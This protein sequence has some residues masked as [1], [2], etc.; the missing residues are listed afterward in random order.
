MSQKRAPPSFIDDTVNSLRENDTEAP[1]KCFDDDDVGLQ[2]KRSNSSLSPCVETKEQ[3][4]QN[5]SN[6]QVLRNN[7]IIRE[8]SVEESSDTLQKNEP[9]ISVPSAN[10]VGVNSNNLHLPLASLI[11]NTQSLDD[12]SRASIMKDLKECNRKDTSRQIIGEY[13][14]AN[15]LRSPVG[16]IPKSTHKQSSLPYYR[17]RTGSGGSS[18][19][20]RNRGTNKLENKTM[21][22]LIGRLELC[23]ISPDRHQ[24]L[25]NKTFNYVSHCSQGKVHCDH[26]GFICKETSFN[27]AE[28]YV[29]YIFKCQSEKLV[30]EI[31]KALKQ[32]FQNAHQSYQSN[33]NKATVICDTCPMHWFHRICC[34]VEGLPPQTAQT[35]I[36][37]RIESL[38]EQDQSDIMQA[39][40]G[41]NVNSIQ[42]QNEILIM[43]LRKMSERRQL[44]H[45]HNQREHPLLEKKSSSSAL[46]NLKQKAKKSLSNSFETILKLAHGDSSDLGTTPESLSPSSASSKNEFFGDD[47][48]PRPRSSTIGG[49]SAKEQDS[50]PKMASRSESTPLQQPKSPLFNIFSKIGS[51][52]C[53]ATVPEENAGN[54]S[55]STTQNIDN[56]WRKAILTNIQNN[57]HS[58]DT[59]KNVTFC[60]PKPKTKEEIRSMWKKAINEHIVLIRMEKE[61]KKLQANQSV[62]SHKRMK[63][64]YFEMNNFGEDSI[65]LWDQLM[66]KS[67]HEKSE[68]DDAV[69]NDSSKGIPKQKRGEIW[70]FLAR[71]QKENSESLT[72][73]DIDLQT[74]YRRLLQQ[75]TEQQHAILVDLGRTFP[76][77]PYYAQPLGA[78]QLSLFNLLKAYSLFDK[79]VGYCQGLS[80]VAGILLLHMNEDDAFEMMKHLLFFH[81]LRKQYTPDMS[82]L[83]MQLYKLT[84]LLYDFHRDLYDHF[85]RYDISPTLY[86]AP[87][88]LTLFASQFSI[89]FVARLFDLIFMSGLEAVFRVSFTLLQYFKDSL[90]HCQSFES[91]MDFL[92]NNLPSMDT[93]QTK[94]IF[95]TVFALNFSKELSVYEIEYNVLLEE[96]QFSNAVSMAVEKEPTKKNVS[97]A[98]KEVSTETY[99][100]IVEKLKEMEIDNRNL[101]RE[102]MEVVD[103]LHVS[104]STVHSLESSL[105]NYKSTIKRLETRARSSEDE[106]EALLQSLNILRLR[107][108]KL[109]SMGSETHSAESD[110]NTPTVNTVTECAEKS[111]SLEKDDSEI[112]EKDETCDT[113]CAAETT[114]T[115]VF[116]EKSVELDND[117]TK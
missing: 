108:E 52:S 21:L 30:E 12:S 112:S 34:D 79:E 19:M 14:S 76:K 48:G 68:I 18:D 23:L 98:S 37:L 67:I 109:E 20:K 41:I 85:E 11:P 56:S 44:K 113:D 25:L 60:E 82:A 114:T 105:D 17:P 73:S 35:K 102:Y 93:E 9:L 74:P 62:A 29:G 88:F 27:S 84:R 104:Q 38:A 94:H 95:E 39:Y 89:G 55:P 40:H 24:V 49:T 36:F 100:E 54:L 87:W 80:F 92:K 69:K 3:E 6:V 65:Q 111:E 58:R 107:L 16:D 64:D 86:A 75:L 117:I 22:F 61:N 8:A 59:R 4:E 71:Q 99:S 97:F 91:I 115:T 45:T 53:P 50:S 66:K 96:S 83:Q 110:R 101:R 72:R 106:R 1:G 90:L 7:I 70:L 63:L 33:K 32:A 28:T 15:N 47:F 5:T 10:K 78:G 81:G 77:H 51:K 46:D 2:M 116:K 26:F 57:D 103:Q 43:L 42:E 13:E 31:M